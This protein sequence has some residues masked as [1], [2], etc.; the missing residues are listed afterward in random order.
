MVIEGSWK[1][2][3]LSAVTIGLMTLV[4]PR[5]H[6]RS[7]EDMEFSRED[8][9]R[10]DGK[11]KF[12]RWNCVTKQSLSCRVMEENKIKRFES[13]YARPPAL[14]AAPPALALAPAFAFDLVLD[15]APVLEKAPT[16]PPALPVEF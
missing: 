12:S 13:T 7:L 9:C 6:R 1:N 14:Y 15:V 5:K 2:F 11:L 4:E 8:R 10:I 3:T 16:V